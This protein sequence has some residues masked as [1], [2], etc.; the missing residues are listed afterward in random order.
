MTAPC[1]RKH[2]P[3][4]YWV[5]GANA[6]RDFRQD[7]GGPEVP[8]RVPAK[9]NTKRWCR[10]RVGRDHSFSWTESRWS[11]R[12]LIE[13]CDHCGKHRGYGYARSARH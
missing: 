6:R 9:K 2:R 3:I 8:T 11:D 10:G 5:A 13:V 4:S 1:P 7:R 12:L